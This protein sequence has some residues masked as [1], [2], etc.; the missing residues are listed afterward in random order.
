MV[1]KLPSVNLVEPSCPR[2]CC[3]HGHLR[4][5]A[6][7]Y[8]G[9]AVLE[10]KGGRRGEGREALKVPGFTSRASLKGYATV[11]DAGSKRN[12][13]TSGGS[14]HVSSAG[15]VGRV[16]HQ[17][18]RRRAT[19]VRCCTPTRAL[20]KSLASEAAWLR[21]TRMGKAE[22]CFYTFLPLRPK[23]F[24]LKISCHPRLGWL[25]CDG[26]PRAS[27]LVGRG[28]GMSGPFREV[29]PILKLQARLRRQLQRSSG[30]LEVSGGA[31]WRRRCPAQLAGAA[32]RVRGGGQG[33][34]RAQDW[35]LPAAWRRRLAGVAGKP[36]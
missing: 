12:G 3:D 11:L 16:L 17:A 5:A 9:S 21:G 20:Q 13:M 7:G 18:R 19:S 15:S 22:D 8:L 25:D 4:R 33:G 28:P 26:R 32:G 30:L 1:A 14:T 2:H 27:L 10:G 35:A 23:P 6:S 36:L 24:W 29:P 31:A 34:G